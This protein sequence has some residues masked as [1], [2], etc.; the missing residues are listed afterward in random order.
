MKASWLML[1]LGLYKGY[2]LL[3]VGEELEK[4]TTHACM[5]KLLLVLLLRILSAGRPGRSEV[6]S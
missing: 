3:P 4:K 5:S 2:A 6:T 1:L